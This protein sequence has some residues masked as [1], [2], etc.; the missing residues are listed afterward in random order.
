M[1][2][3]ALSVAISCS[4]LSG[5]ASIVSGTEQ[6]L[7]FNS[8]PDGATVIVSGKAV[9]KTP[10]SVPIKKG[11]N[12]ALLFK[13]DGYK[14][15]TTQLSTTTDGWF[16]GNIVFGGFLGSTTDGVSGAINEFSPDQYFVTLVQENSFGVISSNSRKIK[17][18]VVALG[19]AIRSE[20]A[21]G[22]GESVNSLV[23]LLNTDPASRENT[24][25]TL[26]NLAAQTDN[27]FDLATKIVQFYGIQ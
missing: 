19:P 12:Q 23:S 26:Q 21:A 25:K 16:W 15:F 27:D 7:T 20:L 13:K 11:K 18:L 14:D 17:E 22:Q 9:G 10:V 4:L 6:T 5:C 24:I 3:Q 2:A 1:K 8:V